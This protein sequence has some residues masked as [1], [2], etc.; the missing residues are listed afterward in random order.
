MLTDVH[1]CGCWSLRDYDAVILGVS[2]L[3]HRSDVPWLVE[4]SVLMNFA[5]KREKVKYINACMRTLVV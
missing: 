1:I 3:Q 2:V 4:I 5:Y